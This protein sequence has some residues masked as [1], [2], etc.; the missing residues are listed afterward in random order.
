MTT[1]GVDYLLCFINQTEAAVV[2]Q[3]LGYDYGIEHNHNSGNLLD[4]STYPNIANLTCQGDEASPSDCI[5]TTDLSSENENKC[6]NE[7]HTQ[8]AL[9]LS[10]YTVTDRVKL[11]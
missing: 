5:V 9:C 10:E 3:A 4:M 2:C 11:H 1:G 6:R 8:A 7:R